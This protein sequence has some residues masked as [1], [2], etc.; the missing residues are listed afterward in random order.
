SILELVRT[1][2]APTLRRS[3]EIPPRIRSG[4]AA[5][6]N[7]FQFFFGG[8]F[9]VLSNSQKKSPAPDEVRDFSLCEALTYRATM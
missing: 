2:F 9:F 4:F 3:E 5:R 7:N 1:H 8:K 6:F